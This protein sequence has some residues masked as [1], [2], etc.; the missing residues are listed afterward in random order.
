MTDL[1]AQVAQVPQVSEVVSPYD[2]AGARQISPD[3][4]IAYAQITFDVEFPDITTDTK[5]QLT[6]LIDQ[7]NAPGIQVEG[8][9]VDLHQP[10]APRRHRGHRPARRRRHPADRLRLGAGHGPAHPHRAVRHRR[11]VRHRRA[12]LPRHLGARV[13]H[14]AGGHDRHRRRHRLRAV[15]RHPLPAGPPRG[16]RPRDLGG[17]RARHRRSGRALRRHHRRHLAA[18]HAA[19]RHRVRRRPRRRA[20]PPWSPSR[21]SPRSRCCRPCS[22]S[23]AATSTSS[24][25]RAPARCATPARPPATAGATSCSATR[26]RSP[27]SACSILLV[28]ALPVVSIRLGSSDESNSPDHRRPPAGPTT[29]RPRASVP[30]PAARC[31]SPPRSAAPTTCRRCRQVVDDVKAT[32]GVAQVSPPRPNEAVDAAIIQVIPTTSSQDA[33]TVD[34][35]EHLRDDVLPGGH[36]RHRRQGARRRRHRGVRRRGHQAAGAAAAV[37]RRRARP[38]LPAAAWSCSARSSCRSRP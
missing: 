13:R 2:Q 15:H 14:P 7:A 16:A 20:R 6:D 1:F 26:G 18:R 35:I 10:R 23:S 31:C 29:S 22:A 32:P 11:R 12:A 24:S 21:W 27:P 36:R 5:D 8:G 34:L 30:A 28:L 25:C 37:H 9:G 17:H 4:P 38:Q 3:A 33:A 19:H